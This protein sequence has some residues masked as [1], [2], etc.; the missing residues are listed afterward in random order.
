MNWHM[1]NFSFP[2]GFQRELEARLQPQPPIPEGLISKFF[3][4]FKKMFTPP[5]VATRKVWGPIL[6][7]YNRVQYNEETSKLELAEGEFVGNCVVTRQLSLPDYDAWSND[8]H[9]LGSGD[10]QGPVVVVKDDILLG[11]CL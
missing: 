5:G 8:D 3:V 9:Y 1:A 10:E 2:F 7:K 4:R 6:V 11:L